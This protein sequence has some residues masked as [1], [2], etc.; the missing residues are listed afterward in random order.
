MEDI[1][2]FELPLPYQANSIDD[3]EINLI[4]SNIGGN[5]FK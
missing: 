5:Y 3:L 1:F 4:T 2:T